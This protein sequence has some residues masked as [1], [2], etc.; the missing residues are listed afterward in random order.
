MSKYLVTGGAG[1]IGS[2]LVDRLISS[3]E[4]VAVIDNLSTGQERNINPKAAFYNADI[5]DSQIGKIFEKEKPRIIFHLA[6]QISV[7]E[8]MIDPARD[9]QVNILGSLNMIKNFFSINYK[10]FG[11]PDVKFVFSSTGGAIYGDVQIFPTPEECPP[12]PL[13]PYG[14]A[15]LAVERYLHCYHKNFKMPYMTLRY[16]NVYGPR[17]N[18]K[19]EAGVVAIFYGNMISGVAPEITGNGKQTRDFIFVG[20]VVE[21]NVMASK[22]QISG[23]W[24]IGTG[25]ETN[26]NKIF[27]TT[28]KNTDKNFKK[29]YIPAR[30]GE[31]QRSC[32]DFSAARRNLGWIPKISLDVGMKKTFEWF[33]N[34]NR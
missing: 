14:V 10:R 20:D 26:I 19:G 34:S 29:K 33:L 11:D 30:A 5:C 31:L 15:K 23:F 22:S 1:F 21:A 8:S 17:Q 12:F 2:H 6:A 3:G 16:S 25:V 9:A 32:L 18:S 7:N 13:S 27:E 24:N 4:S 28:A